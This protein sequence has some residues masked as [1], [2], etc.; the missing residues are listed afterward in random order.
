MDMNS[1]ENTVVCVLPLPSAGETSQPITGFLL[2]NRRR[3]EH[4]TIINIW[5]L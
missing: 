2:F 5:H 4:S 3:S 1:D